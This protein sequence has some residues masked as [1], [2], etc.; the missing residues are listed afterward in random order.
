MPYPDRVCKPTVCRIQIRAKRPQPALR[1][2]RR[3]RSAMWPSRC[4][5]CHRL[6]TETSGS[7]GTPVAP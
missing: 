5:P 6:A 4:R 2:H 7:G 1:R 3:C